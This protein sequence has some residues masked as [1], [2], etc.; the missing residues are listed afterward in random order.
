MRYLTFV[1]GLCCMGAIVFCAPQDTGKKG[2]KGGAKK[3]EVAHPFYWAPADP[4]RGD[5]Q[6]EGYVAQVVRADDRLLSIQDQLPSQ[7][8]GNKY[9]ANI[10]H[11]FDVANDKPIAILHGEASGGDVEFGGDG[12][13]GAIT[14]GHFKAA[15]AG[16]S[17]D[18]Q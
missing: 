6:G 8:D 11:K 17:F 14:A 3:V 18:L 4:L 7:E 2:S 12:W 5:W 16:E 13:T 10:F 1:V 15:K 9:V